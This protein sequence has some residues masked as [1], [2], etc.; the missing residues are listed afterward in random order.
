M[1]DTSKP[2]KALYIAEVWWL[3]SLSIIFPSKT[4]Y[5]LYYLI[6]S[7]SEMLPSIWSWSFLINPFQNCLSY[8][9]P[10]TSK[11]VCNDRSVHDCFVNI[12]LVYAYLF[13]L[14]TLPSST[15]FGFFFI[16][17]LTMCYCFNKYSMF[18]YTLQTFSFVNFLILSASYK[19]TF[20]ML[21]VSLCLTIVNFST[22]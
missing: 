16:S 17:S 3:V 7:T 20:H 9:A 11:Y 1:Q 15:L 5:Y 14:S 8:S 13:F 18:C 4:I 12:F 21:C 19:F 6:W 22:I 10:F 2:L